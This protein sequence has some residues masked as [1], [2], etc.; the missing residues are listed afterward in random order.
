MNLTEFLRRREALARAEKP[1]RGTCW[2]CRQ[3]A[4]F[5]FCPS[6]RPIDTDVHFV[7]L[8]HPI[9]VRRRIA[10]GRMA[11]LCLKNS[12]LIE[13][14]DFSDRPEVRAF[15]EDPANRCVVLYPDRRSLSLSRLTPGERTALTAG[16]RRLVIFVID[17]TWATAG[18][19]RKSRGLIDLPTVSFDPGR[20]SRFR[21]RLQP[22]P[23]C[24]STIEA[25]HQTLEV[26]CVDPAARAHDHLIEVFDQMVEA[27]VRFIEERRARGQLH[28]R[29]RPKG[30][31]CK[32]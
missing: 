12:T 17:G 28:L 13:G 15:T 4:Q 1:F 19:M 29:E 32:F 25:I 9:E 27:Q 18:R 22:A 24:L 11:H 26:L 6:L 23:E 20:P 21:V 30:S 8:I 5:C 10:T 14:I 2:T 7:I 31:G 16:D 3:V